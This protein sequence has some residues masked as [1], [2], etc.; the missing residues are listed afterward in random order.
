MKNGTYTYVCVYLCMNISVVCMSGFDIRTHTHNG[1]HRE[2]ETYIY[3]Y[4]G[5]GRCQKVC[6][7]GG[8]GGGTHTRNVCTFGKEPI[9][10]SCIWIY[11]YLLTSI[12]VSLLK[13]STR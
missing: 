12:C 4:S 6:V 9:S 11:G 13:L 3:I 8:G 5:V 1:T 2:S 7:G 10:T